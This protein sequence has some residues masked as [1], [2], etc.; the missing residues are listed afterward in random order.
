MQDSEDPW[1][2]HP[3]LE[4]SDNPNPNVWYAQSAKHM[5]AVSPSFHRVPVFNETF[6][7]S[8][9]LFLLLLST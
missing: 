6:V 1:T 2:L 3:I 4:P 9:L 5:C 7:F 8:S